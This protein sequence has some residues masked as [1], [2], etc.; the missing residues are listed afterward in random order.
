MQRIFTG[1]GP[2]A[3][4]GLS[5]TASYALSDKDLDQPYQS[6]IRVTVGHNFDGSPHQVEASYFWMSPWNSSAEVF[7]QSGRGLFSPFNNFGAFPNNNVDFANS[8]SI[9]QVSRLEGGDLN[10]K[11]YLPMPACEPT[12]ALMFGVRHIGVREE[13]D[14]MA[15]PAPIVSVHAHTSNDLWGPQI[16]GLV[17]YGHQD[18]W[19]RFE[20]KAAVCDNQT[21][22]DLD[23][24]VGGTDATHP[25]SWKSNTAMV[26]EINA[27]IRWRPTDALTLE[28]GY[29]ALWCDQLALASRNFAPDYP[30]LTNAAAEPLINTR[31]TLIYQ[32]PFAGLQVSW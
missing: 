2:V 5:P 24:L 14:Y 23:A 17:E 8:V 32:G 20:G 15:L 22:R 10:L 7:D 13:F 1:F 9:H 26:A 28:V 16:G 12:I 30:V 31:G 19:L 25:R 3:T 29:Q 18:V 21:T 27:A 11:C 4:L 6:G